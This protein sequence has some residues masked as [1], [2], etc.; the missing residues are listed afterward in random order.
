MNTPNSKYYTIKRILH[1]LL[2]FMIL[3]SINLSCYLNA[4]AAQ[5]LPID[6]S[7]ESTR[8]VGT[9]LYEASKFHNVM[10]LNITAS[11]GANTGILHDE[12]YVTSI[13]F[14]VG[15][16]ITV[17]SD[18]PMYSTFI[19]WDSL[20]PEWTMTID[21]KTYTYGTH[22]YLHEYIV[23]PTPSTSYTITIPDGS[24]LGSLDGVYNGGMRL[25]DIYAFKDE[26]IP[27]WVQIWEPTLEDADIMI[28]TAHSDDEDLFFGGIMPLYGAERGLK[29][30]MVYATE[31]WVYDGTSK[32]REHEKLCGLWVAGAKYYPIVSN[33]RDIYSMDLNSAMQA[34][35]LEDMAK[36]FTKYIRQVK[37]LVVVSHDINGEYGHGQ[38]RLST[39]A[40]EKAV[41]YAS[42]RYYDPD[43]VRTYGTWN[44]P[45]Y[46]KHIYPLNK[47]KLDLRSPLKAFDGKNAITVARQAYLCHE[48]Q[49][50]YSHTSDDYGP[51]SNAEYGLYRATIPLDK[52]HNDLMENITEDNKDE[53][54]HN[55][56]KPYDNDIYTPI[57]NVDDLKLLSENPY[58]RF[59]LMNDLD[60]ADVNWKPIDFFGTFDGANHAILNLCISDFGDNTYTTYDG[61]MKP[62]D[63]YFSA[64]FNSL[65]NAKVSNL[66]LLGTDINVTSECD[67][68]IAPLAGYMYNS[69]IDNCHIKGSAYLATKCKMFGVGG[70]AAFGG[71][72]SIV[73]SSADV[74]LTCI[75]LDKENK[76]E[77]FLGGAYGA[78]YIDVDNTHITIK[79]YDSD[80]GYVHNGGI[81]GLYMFYPYG[82]YHTG[83]ITN[84]SV[85]G[86]IRFFEDN[87]D[88]RA[89]CADLI[90]ETLSRNFNKANNET[91]FIRDEVYD[92]Q[93]DLLPHECTNPSYNT[94]FIKNDCTSYSYT[95]YR[96]T[97]CNDYSY[98]ANYV[99]PRH[100]FNNA[101]G[102][103]EANDTDEGIVQLS[104]S[105]CKAKIYSKLPK[106][107]PVIIKLPESYDETTDLMD[108]DIHSSKLK[109][110]LITV[111]VIAFILIITIV[112]IVVR[113]NKNNK[114]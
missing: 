102:I 22:G 79:G 5:K 34:I 14:N 13:G 98:E 6:Q 90:G 95:V 7:I 53:I 63:T 45:K 49:L 66:S 60:L 27:S 9:D 42:N 1:T 35:P 48:S 108:N 20:V 26:N 31:H 72:S 11:N 104:C 78:G 91:S 37:P 4:N 43:S 28:V 70:I 57:Y 38:H 77:Q 40:T 67:T 52:E 36:C 12:S 15:T 112:F 81:T 33:F 58:G 55:A 62:Y 30:Q 82:T 84:N 105:V 106:D 85:D 94:E 69:T 113:K 92:Y 65:Y 24:V 3:L 21:D 83:F 23:L 64:F 103:I 75:D 89:Y 18:E 56:M 8:D 110:I 17:S 2:A 68:F 99:I 19:I 50:R 88:R 86:F 54:R 44:T 51:Y 47:L 114:K 87:A 46:Y 107:E 61:N 29:V 25:S 109:Y 96:C 10:N 93:T 111:G 39:L 101:N 100:R 73:N 59:R 74:T 80:H 76:D 32:M 41:E 71:N 16:T 97:N